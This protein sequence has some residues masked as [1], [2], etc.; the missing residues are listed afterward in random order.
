L[1][2]K[3]IT[4]LKYWDIFLNICNQI[5]YKKLAAFQFCSCLNYRVTFFLHN[6]VD[7]NI[8]KLIFECFITC[9]SQYKPAKYVSI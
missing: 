5:T 4:V 2:L 1:F 3:Q 7:F 8:V 9:K 6:A